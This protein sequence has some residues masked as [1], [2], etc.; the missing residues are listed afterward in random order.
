MQLIF[1]FIIA[2]YKNQG[3]ILSSNSSK[4]GLLY[5]SYDNGSMSHALLV[6]ALSL[7]WVSCFLL[8]IY[9]NALPFLFC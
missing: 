3:Q 8:A 7:G 6:G 5:F 9:P 1:L 4:G 2:L